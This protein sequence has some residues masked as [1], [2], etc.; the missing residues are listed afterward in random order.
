MFLQ[1]DGFT[2]LHCASQEGH[3]KVVEVLVKAGANLDT[4]ILDVSTVWLGI[5]EVLNFAV[6][7][8]QP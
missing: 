8:D 4:K 7:V 6:S 1:R 3:V 5:Y 2:A